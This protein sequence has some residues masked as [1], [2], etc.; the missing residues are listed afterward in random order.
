MIL[1]SVKSDNIPYACKTIFNNRKYLWKVSGNS[2]LFVLVC[3]VL[4]KSNNISDLKSFISSN[5]NSNFQEPEARKIIN[6]W[7]HNLESN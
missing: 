6:T 5:I 3:E 1:I 7:R 4:F 2:K